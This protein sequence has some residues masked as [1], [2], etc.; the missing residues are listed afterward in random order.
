ML[1]TKVKRTDQTAA[2]LYAKGHRWPDLKLFD[3]GELQVVGLD[4]ASLPV[5]VEVPCRFWAYFELSEK[6]NQAGHP[7]KDVVALEPTDRPATSMSTDNSAIL[8]ELRA[9]RALL[10]ILVEAQ[11]LQLP[12]VE[13][14]A[15]GR[16]TSK[17]N[18]QTSQPAAETSQEDPDLAAVFPRYADGSPVGNNQA[19]L[20]AWHAFYQ[21]WAKPPKDLD[22][23]RSWYK[24][25]VKA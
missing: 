25:Q 10:G 24:E 12:E 19:E 5:G 1:I 16:D 11:G 13:T 14:S 21:Q 23:L 8:A 22:A 2:D 20:E 6:L 17:G 9:I 15:G 7:Y 18:E 3:L 4:P